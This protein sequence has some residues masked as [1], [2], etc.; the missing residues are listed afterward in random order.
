MQSH[1]LFA[2]GVQREARPSLRSSAVYTLQIN[3]DCHEWM[4][5]FTVAIACTHPWMICTRCIT[6]AE[7]YHE[8]SLIYDLLHF[9]AKS[10]LDR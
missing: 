1:S 7:R 10:P 4:S 9:S 3:F 8:K 2:D 6:L 5:V